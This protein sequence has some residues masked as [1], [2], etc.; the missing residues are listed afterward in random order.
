MFQ[1]GGRHD[2]G[3]AK[4]NMEYLNGTSDGRNCQELPDAMDAREPKKKKKK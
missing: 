4:G 1:G 3:V 2:T